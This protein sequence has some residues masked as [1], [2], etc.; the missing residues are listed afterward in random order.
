MSSVLQGVNDVRADLLGAVN[1]TPLVLLAD[2]NTLP[3]AQQLL[4]RKDQHS[5][6]EA[7][8]E[9]QPIDPLQIKNLWQHKVR[10]LLRQ[11]AKP[12]DLKTAQISGTT[13]QQGDNTSNEGVD[14]EVTSVV[15]F[16]ATMGSSEFENSQFSTG[17]APT[18][19]YTPPQATAPAPR[20]RRLEG[21]PYTSAKKTQIAY[22]V[23][24]Q[25]PPQAFLPQMAALG[26]FHP[27]WVPPPPT[28]GAVWGC[29]VPPGLC[30][31]GNNILT[32]GLPPPL[33]IQ[34]PF[35]GPATALV[36]PAAK[37]AA[38]PAAQN[39][40][41]TNNNN[42]NSFS[43]RSELPISMLASSTIAPMVP[44][45]SSQPQSAHGNKAQ[46]E[47]NL[48]MNAL[49]SQTESEMQPNFDFDNT[50]LDID[51]EELDSLFYNP[52]EV[53]DGEMDAL[54]QLLECDAGGLGN[55]NRNCSFGNLES[56]G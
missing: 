21:D 41:I 29:P 51:L 10:K 1:E 27:G 25:L 19:S 40:H 9:S 50:D 15:R 18:K 46:L 56:L 20:K 36:I 28:P 30:A 12:Q 8:L 53:V 23:P 26:A 11:H 49:L 44:C 13:N 48:N 31:G 4:K 5:P 16:P 14:S 52:G 47:N 32:R 2:N 38:K 24:L 45:S 42:A 37:P 7:V 22:Q 34:H 39:P 54:Q 55:L 35:L 17:N 43:K 6:L 3:Q 33:L